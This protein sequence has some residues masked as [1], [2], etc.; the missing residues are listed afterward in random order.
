LVGQEKVVGAFEHPPR[1]VAHDRLC[2][3]REVSKHDVRMPS[4]KETDS[5]GINISTEESHCTG[6]TK[7]ARADL[8]SKETELGTKRTDG[9][10]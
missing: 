8:G 4:A 2:L 3:Y 5:V 10:S 9:R 1:K 6:S 7:R